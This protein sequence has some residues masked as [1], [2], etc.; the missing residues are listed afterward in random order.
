M[1]PQRIL[2]IQEGGCACGAVRFRA[3]GAPKRV[4]ICHCMTCRRINGSVFGCY[5]IFERNS[6]AFFGST[7]VWQSSLHARL[8]FCPTCGSV[9]FT[10]YTNSS[11]IDV[12]L[13]AFD[14]TG[15]YEP[16][17]ELWCRRR[18]PWLPAGVRTEYQ[19]DRQP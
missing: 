12:P 7:Q 5:A 10:E 2:E 4:G 13:G 17:Y 15:L 6:L 1:E 16:T 14:R 9:T 11:E 18:E 8:H 19:Q 3:S